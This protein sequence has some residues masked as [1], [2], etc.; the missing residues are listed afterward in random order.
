VSGEG[1]NLEIKVDEQIPDAWFHN[2]ADVVHEHTTLS[3]GEPCALELY[4]CFAKSFD[5]PRE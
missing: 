5:I 3:S 1:L 4:A 2:R